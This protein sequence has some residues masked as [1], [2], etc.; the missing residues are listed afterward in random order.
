MEKDLQRAIEKHP[1]NQQLKIV[2]DVFDEIFNPNNARDASK[3]GNGSV[4]EKRQE[5]TPITADEQEECNPN[6]EDDL[7]KNILDQLEIIDLLHSEE[8]IKQ[9]STLSDREKR[10]LDL[11]PSFSLGP[12]IDIVSQVCSDINKEH[13]QTVQTD[14]FLTPKPLVR[15]KSTR[16]IKLGPYAKSPYNNRVIDIN[17]KYTSEDITLWRYMLIPDR[18]GL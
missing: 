16:L 5:E 15:E 4:S 6:D 1:N 7:D 14:D 2:K 13:Q 17:A 10:D 9:I 12:E 11:V 18:D 8:G 3:N